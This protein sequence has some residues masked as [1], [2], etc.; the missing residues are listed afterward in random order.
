MWG[1]H[2]QDGVK[3][4]FVGCA[5]SNFMIG[6]PL[7]QEP[8]AIVI[9][10]AVDSLRAVDA[11]FGSPV[12]GVS[13]HYCVGKGGE[14]HQY[15]HETDTAFHAG[16]VD[17]PK[18]PLIKP[19]INPNYYTIGIEH[20]GLPDDIWP[21]IQIITSAALVSEIARRWNIPLDPLH[22]ILHRHIRSSKSCPG[23]FITI[24][25]LLRHL[26]RTRLQNIA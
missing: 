7:N 9:H 15:V 23:S 26:P 18:W 14:V 24:E 6:R 10:I 21:E 22:I 3:R 13:A 4:T 8:E 20:E 5:A 1:N 17:N 2:E 11:Y 25:K 16:V 12:S 19:G